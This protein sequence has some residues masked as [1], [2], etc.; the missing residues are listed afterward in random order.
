MSAH[1]DIINIILLTLCHSDLFQPS[2]GYRQG[3]RQP[4][5]DSKV[6]KKKKMS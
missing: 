2:K 3:V 6:K 5:F 4:Q 1:T